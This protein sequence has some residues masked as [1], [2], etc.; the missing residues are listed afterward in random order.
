MAG[1]EDAA[2]PIVELAVD[3]DGGRPSGIRVLPDGRVESRFGAGSWT[4]QWRY[5]AGALT[6]L[7][8]AVADADSPPLDSRY[9]REG[10]VSHPTRIVWTLR[11]PT[12]STTVTVEK[13][14][15]GLV[16]PLDRLYR[17]IFELRP[18][19]GG[20]SVWRVRVGDRVVERVLNCEPAS[21]PQLTPLVAALFDPGDGEDGRAA[22]GDGDG[23]PLVEIEWRTSGR[24]TERTVVHSDGRNVSVRDGAEHE[25]RRYSAAE[26]EAIVRAIEA[27][28]WASLPDPVC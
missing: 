11:T 1:T 18:D 28:G 19:D 10:G 16:P 23:K 13:Y 17:R 22:E 9:E 24:T 14:A 4:E 6:E 26:V 3:P 7:R 15:P 27:V 2:G 8:R 12:R 21:V 5:E 25:D 20:S